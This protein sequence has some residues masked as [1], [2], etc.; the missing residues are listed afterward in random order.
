MGFTRALHGLH[1]GFAGVPCDHRVLASIHPGRVRPGA[2]T[3]VDTP[4]KGC[5]TSPGAL[6]CVKL[7]VSC[8]NLSQVF[9]KGLC[10]A[11]GARLGS[12]FS[13]TRT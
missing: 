8:V 2:G 11:H 9:D 10:M 7:Y 4:P 1:E 12:G 3:L 6:M 13:A 5:R